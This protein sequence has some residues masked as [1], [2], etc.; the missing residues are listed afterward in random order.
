MTPPKSITEESNL[1]SQPFQPLTSFR[2]QNPLTS[3]LLSNRVSRLGATPQTPTGLLPA[4]KRCTVVVLTLRKPL[5][6]FTAPPTGIGV[7]G[8]D[9]GFESI[10][11]A[12]KEIAPIV[13][14]A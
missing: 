9:F 7:D 8:E 6:G 14:S 13:P 1:S 10:T 12:D 11:S 2:P 4:G 3:V 5:K